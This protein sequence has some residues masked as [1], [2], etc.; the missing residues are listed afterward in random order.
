MV[1]CDNPDCE[2]KWFHLHH[3]NLHYM[4]DEDDSWVCTLCRGWEPLNDGEDG[5][6][7]CPKCSWEIL[8]ED[9]DYVRGVTSKYAPRGCERCKLEQ[10]DP[11]QLD[12]DDRESSDDEEDDEGQDEDE[13]SVSSEEAED[14]VEVEENYIDSDGDSDG[15][16][17]DGE[18]DYADEDEESESS[19]EEA[20]DD[21]IEHDDD[22]E[23]AE[24]DHDDVEGCDEGEDD[25][26][27]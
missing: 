20:D 17:E 3:T 6:W 24:M 5:C 11:W 23:D 1:A 16:S 12:F 19:E 14:G 26:Y 18:M 27:D 21:E 4:P 13:R 7:R 8:D 10:G 15:D 2:R 22:G 9:D 25:L